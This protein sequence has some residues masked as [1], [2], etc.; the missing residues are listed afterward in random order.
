MTSIASRS[1]RFFSSHLFRSS[2]LA[3]QESSLQ[4]APSPRPINRVCLSR[5]MASKVDSDLMEKMTREEKK[6]TGQDNPV[7]GGPTAQAQKH[8]NQP[9]TSDV[10]HDITRGEEKITG[11]PNP[12]PAGPTSTAQSI[13]TRVRFPKRQYTPCNSRLTCPKTDRKTPTN[14]Q[15]LQQL[16]QSA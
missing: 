3:F 1:T 14:I 5:T 10:I 12:K 6:I 4:H 2:T 15:Q 9:L 16:Q 7:K 13:L 8:A 11:N